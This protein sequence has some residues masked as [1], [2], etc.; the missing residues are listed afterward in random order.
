[1][2]CVARFSGKSFMEDTMSRYLLPVLLLLTLAGHALAAPLLTARGALSS[3]SPLLATGEFHQ[4]QKVN[5]EAGMLVSLKAAAEGFP[6]YLVANAPDG[7][8]FTRGVSGTARQVQ[9][10]FITTKAG[11]CQIAVT[12]EKP[13]QSGTFV[14]EGESRPLQGGIAGLRPL[15]NKQAKVTTTD[16]DL[17]QGRRAHTH[18]VTIQAGQVIRV[19]AESAAFDAL[20]AVTPPGAATIQA[21]DVS[22]KNPEVAFL[23]TKAGSLK[24]MV[25]SA[26]AKGRG[27]YRLQVMGGS[28]ASAS[29]SQTPTTAALL[30]QQ[31]SLG[32]G[33]P[34]LQSGEWGQLYGVDLV[35]GQS[36]VLRVKA[37]GFQPRLLAVLPDSKEVDQRAA[38]TATEIKV[39]LTAGRSGLL[40]FCIASTRPRVGGSFR[41]DVAPETAPTSTA[42]VP[43]AALGPAPTTPAAA[44]R[45]PRVPI[46]PKID[47]TKFVDPKD[48]AF[49]VPAPRPL[50]AT[51][52]D[53]GV[54]AKT[55]HQM[56][57]ICVE[58]GGWSEMNETNWRYPRA[59]DTSHGSPRR[60]TTDPDNQFDDGDGYYTVPLRW[61]GNVFT[62]QHRR[63][64]DTRGNIEMLDVTG[65]VTPDGDRVEWVLIREYVQ[66]AYWNEEEKLSLLRRRLY[67]SISLVDLPLRNL[68]HNPETGLGEQHLTMQEL[69][70]G[71]PLDLALR[72]GLHYGYSSQP[73]A[74]KHVL[75]LGYLEQDPAVQGARYIDRDNIHT[76]EYRSTN[77]SHPTI[78]PT[79]KL[80]FERRNNVRP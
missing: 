11:V 23:S 44:P 28:L 18:T 27:A 22:N 78:H 47:G 54:L 20:L 17:G 1:M 61:N 31:G 53:P 42:S 13:G 77:W 32:A 62:C 34:Q 59:N 9:L 51:V 14:L 29:P 55:L 36:Y 10:D 2:Q 12:T 74:G 26:D 64:I 16:Q 58:A 69:L 39:A 38:G 66:E 76:V 30:A 79:A 75:D 6:P 15:F 41:V 60:F 73:E 45:D 50:P 72:N 71:Q 63:N 43:G 57:Y 46:R 5:V 4:V 7:R 35:A 65:T 48:P 3:R 37:Q 70:R 80:S 68:Y 33:S 24:I 52:R 49:N 25:I 56:N 19:L 67:R 40:K 21:D 8:R